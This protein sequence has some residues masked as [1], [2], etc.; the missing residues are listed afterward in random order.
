MPLHIFSK[1]VVT[2]VHT[3]WVQAAGA[4]GEYDLA[5]TV[6]EQATTLRLNINKDFIPNMMRKIGAVGA[7]RRQLEKLYE[8]ERQ[9]RGE[10]TGGVAMVVHE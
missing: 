10:A 2:W 6:L 9:T 5:E 3:T 1:L 8:I 4:A 7:G